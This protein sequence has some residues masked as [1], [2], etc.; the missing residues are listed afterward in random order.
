ML[1]VKNEHQWV[2]ICELKQE[3]SKLSGQSSAQ[4]QSSLY[5][6]ADE[7]LDDGSISSPGDTGMPCDLT[8]AGYAA[9]LDENSPLPEWA[10]DEEQA[11]QHMMTVLKEP[12]RKFGG[13]FWKHLMALGAHVVCCAASLRK[14]FQKHVAF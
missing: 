14:L 12:S 5:S 2:T 4:Q 7:V 1:N 13:K 10:H 8:V 11:V 9:M 3:I 6:E